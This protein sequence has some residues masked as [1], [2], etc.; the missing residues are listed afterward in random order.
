[1]GPFADVLCRT[2]HVSPTT[3]PDEIERALKDYLNRLSDADLLSFRATLR[4]YETVQDARERRMAELDAQLDATLAQTQALTTGGAVDPVKAFGERVDKKVDGG[5]TYS[6]A[7]RDVSREQPELYEKYRNATFIDGRIRLSSQ[8][9]ASTKLA[10]ATM[11]RIIGEN[12]IVDQ[13]DDANYQQ[14]D[15]GNL[16]GGSREHPIEAFLRLVREVQSQPGM[17]AALAIENVKAK[18][19]ALWEAYNNAVLAVTAR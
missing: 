5:M 2:L 9:E 7:L 18:Y 19:P 17:D 3:P 10:S 8:A 4:E 1:M 13:P 12:T 14:L 16:R 15:S 11:A 6:Q